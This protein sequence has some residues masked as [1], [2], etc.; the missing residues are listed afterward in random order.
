VDRAFHTA[1]LDPVLADFRD[2]CGKVRPRPTRTEFVSGLDGVR[3][4]VGWLPDADHLVRGTR[5]PVDFAAVLRTLERT[6]GR[7]VQ[8]EIGPDAPLTG[9]VRRARPDAAAVPTQR[10]GDPGLG[11]LWA[12]VAR[13]HCAGRRLDW[14][15][16][17]DGCDARRIPLPPYP[18]QHRSYWTGPPPTPLADDRRT[19]DG[20]T[21]QTEQ[22]EQAG[23]DRVLMLSARHLGYTPEEITAERTFVGLGAESLQL[24]GM[25]RQ[26]EA[27]FGVEIGMREILEEAGTPRLAARLITER[28]GQGASASTGVTPDDEPVRA[29]ADEEPV[30]A[31]R[32]EEPGY[33][34]RAEVEELARQ[35]RQLAE[36]QTRML[37]QLSEAVALLAEGSK[38]VGG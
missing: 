19:E 22:T 10:R 7:P 11:I 2:A 17:L 26:L 35:I 21:E 33:A 38:A 8:L 15:A 3:H 31:P 12:A 13:L 16:L 5:R 32:T 20:M 27:E 37:G 6:P 34:T 18:F 28:T 36:T 9:L 1:L 30:H 4:P 25:V 23:L 29:A 24:I 14:A